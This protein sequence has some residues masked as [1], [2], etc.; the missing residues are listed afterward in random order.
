MNRWVFNDRC[1]MRHDWSIKELWNRELYLTFRPF[2]LQLC[3]SLFRGKCIGLCMLCVE[4][5]HKCFKDGRKVLVSI[6]YRLL[7][8]KRSEIWHGKRKSCWKVRLQKKV[9][10]EQRK[11]QN[12]LHHPLRLFCVPGRT[13]LW[14]TIFCIDLKVHLSPYVGKLVILSKKAGSFSYW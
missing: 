2:S 3:C 11:A 6:N 13:H 1:H 14:C 5:Q 4:L 8:V 12:R 7:F 9:S 10:H